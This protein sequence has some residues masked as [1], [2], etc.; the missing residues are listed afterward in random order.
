MLPGLQRLQYV[1]IQQVIFAIAPFPGPHLISVGSLPCVHIWEMGWDGQT[2][3]VLRTMKPDFVE[4]DT[5]YNE[6]GAAVGMAT[7]TWKPARCVQMTFAV[8]RVN[9]INGFFNSSLWANG[10]VEAN[11]Y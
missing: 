1:D 4:I 9:L 2:E 3:S 6:H 11:L 5:L 10:K 7:P 8:L